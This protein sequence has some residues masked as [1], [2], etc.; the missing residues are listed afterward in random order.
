[1][2][3]GRTFN[4]LELLCFPKG[5]VIEEESQPYLATVLVPQL[6][7]RGMKAAEW[8]RGALML[9]EPYLTQ[10]KAVVCRQCNHDECSFNR[11]FRWSEELLGL[12][13]GQYS[14][15][16]AK[17]REL[18]AQ[19]LSAETRQ[20]LEARGI[21][22]GSYQMPS[23]KNPVLSFLFSRGDKTQRVRCEIGKRRLWIDEH[24]EILVSTEQIRQ[25]LQEAIALL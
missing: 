23:R 5:C 22:A 24:S 25:K 8:T 4:L 1:M 10:I 15:R 21:K 20:E 19:L 13:D 6:E 14:D 3:S 11:K 16:V 7:A 18:Q 17:G 9:E 12:R 2:E